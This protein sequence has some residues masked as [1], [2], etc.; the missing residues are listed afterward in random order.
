MKLLTQTTLMVVAKTDPTKSQDGKTIYYRLACIQNGQATNL[1]VATQEVYD[2][3]PDGFVEARFNT[4]YDDKYGTLKIDSI[5]EIISVN[6]VKSDSKP[7][8][9]PDA[10]AAGNAPDKK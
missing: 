10:K 3:V 4:L 9:K 6:G 8:P 2:A 1:S 5:D 7:D